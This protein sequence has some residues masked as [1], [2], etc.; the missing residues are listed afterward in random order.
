MGLRMPAHRMTAELDY[1]QDVWC[2]REPQQILAPL[3]PFTTPTQPVKAFLPLIPRLQASRVKDYRRRG[4]VGRLGCGVRGHQVPP[5][6]AGS[7][8]SHL[9]SLSLSSLIPRM[10]GIIDTVR[11]AVRR[12]TTR[13]VKRLG[14]SLIHRTLGMLASKLRVVGLD[15]VPVPKG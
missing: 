7:R 3:S 4:E 15:S 6:A 9:I 14:Q 1:K 11:I 8:E 2:A 12:E 5:G 10:G 13:D